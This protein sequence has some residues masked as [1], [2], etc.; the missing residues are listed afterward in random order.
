[1]NKKYCSIYPKKAFFYNK[2]SMWD[3]TAITILRRHYMCHYIV[4]R[5]SSRDDNDLAWSA[6][7]GVLRDKVE[8]D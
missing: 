2:G 6:V 8:S 4:I 1:M 5:I 7:F 3:E